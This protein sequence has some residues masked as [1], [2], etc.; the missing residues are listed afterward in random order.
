[1]MLKVALRNHVE[2]SSLADA[3]ANTMLSI[4]A[5]ILTVALP[6]MIPNL[7]S[8]PKLAIPLLVLL[9]TTVISL[10]IATLVTR[11][12]KMK[13]VTSAEAIKAGRGDLFFFGNFFNMPYDTYLDGMKYT[14]ANAGQLEDSVIRDLF[15]S[16]ATLGKKYRLLRICYTVFMVGIIL[17]AI[18][19]V[20]SQ[21]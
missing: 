12:S 11:P 7:Q 18:G 19:L 10:A 13:G 9:I 21:V 1:M 16:G 20:I 8:N 5:I 14:I 6:L 4:N 3:K 2:L 15:L 17:T